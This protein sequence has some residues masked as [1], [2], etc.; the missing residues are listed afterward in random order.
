MA[1]ELT[2]MGRLNAIEGRMAELDRNA[3]ATMWEYGNLFREVAQAALYRAAGFESFPDW[4]EAV[5]RSRKTA[6]KLMAVAEHFNAEMASRWGT[7]KLYA[8]VRYLEATRKVEEA[9]DA[10]A[11]RFRIRDHAGW[12]TV[13]FADASYRQIE[14]ARR[15]L[16]ESR[17]GKRPRPPKQILERASR[18]ADVL[19]PPPKG[20]RRRDRVRLQSGADGRLAVSFSAIPLDELESFLVA[21]RDHLLE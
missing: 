3:A 13:P 16:E 11:L 4:L 17:R 6:R 15:L 8:T 20:V 1:D 5:G 14:E 9:G 7:E 21:V 2:D 18:L 12:T 10:P 19:P